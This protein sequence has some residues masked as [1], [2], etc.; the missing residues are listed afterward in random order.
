MLN[1]QIK[2]GKSNIMDKLLEEKR[3][4]LIQEMIFLALLIILNNKLPIS[5]NHLIGLLPF[6]DH[7]ETL[8]SSLM[9]K[10]EIRQDPNMK[11]I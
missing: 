6:I 10:G 7:Q 2:S 5:R 3:K 11:E 1:I 9:I 4:S 8:L